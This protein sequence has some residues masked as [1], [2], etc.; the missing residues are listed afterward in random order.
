MKSKSIERTPHRKLTKKQLRQLASFTDPGTVLAALA[1]E[2]WSVEE[3]IQHLV[4]IAK[5]EDEGIK[6]STQLNAIRYL[7]QLII[8]A[9]ERS[10]LMVMATKKFVGEDGGEVRF[11]GH[12]VSSVLKE[13][14]EE[15]TPANLITDTIPE[16]N[17]KGD[18]KENGI[19]KNGDNRGKNGENGEDESLE[20]GKGG[21]SGK[22]EP[23]SSLHTTKPPTGREAKSG[24]F[25]GISKQGED[26]ISG[27]TG[28]FI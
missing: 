28:D 23:Q 20:S 3:S 12:V 26:N 2:G 8:D 27:S 5:G 6:T 17:H 1:K 13:Q 10:G 7:N 9:M 14:K 19:P 22:V 15:T 16:P 21:E 18:K 24:H 25:D 4:V 11:S